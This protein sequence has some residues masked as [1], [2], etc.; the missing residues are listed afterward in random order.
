M[1]NQYLLN[2]SPEDAEWLKLWIW[3][4][5]LHRDQQENTYVSDKQNE[6]MQGKKT[7]MTKLGGKE[8]VQQRAMQ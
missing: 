5:F 4:R 2:E 6:E 8:K 1:H 7:E 3:V